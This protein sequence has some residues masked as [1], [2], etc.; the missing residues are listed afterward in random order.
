MIN[1]KIK[2]KI[3]EVLNE[4]FEIPL[5]KLKPDAALFTD[6][7]LDSLDIVDLIVALEK[8]FK[9][10]IRTESAEAFRDVRTLE[11]LYTVVQK[12]YENLS[13]NDSTQ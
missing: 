3:D 6:L 5:K 12:M 2:N 9:I 10:K 11:D 7:E 8:S 13:S 4:E 1:Q